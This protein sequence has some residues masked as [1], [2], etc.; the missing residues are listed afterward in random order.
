METLGGLLIYHRIPSGGLIPKSPNQGNVGATKAI[1]EV[2][3][4]YFVLILGG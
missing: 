1:W 3:D 4:V 2:I